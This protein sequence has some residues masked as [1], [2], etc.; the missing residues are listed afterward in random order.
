M[1]HPTLLQQADAPL[2]T[3]LD[4]TDKLSAEGGAHATAGESPAVD[5]RR[6]RRERFG[7][8]GF[9]LTTRETDGQ[10]EVRI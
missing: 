2:G 10:M 5:R 9:H 6:R 8:S 7:F 4:T 1:T 3:A